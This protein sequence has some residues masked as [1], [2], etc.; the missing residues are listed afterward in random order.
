MARRRRK[1]EK[2]GRGRRG[3]TWR[4]VRQWPG[5]HFWATPFEVFTVDSSLVSTPVGHICTDM[6]SRIRFLQV[7]DWNCYKLGRLHNCILHCMHSNK[8]IGDICIGLNHHMPFRPSYSLSPS[9]VAVR[10]S[11]HN[12]NIHHLLH[13]IWTSDAPVLWCGPRLNIDTYCHILRPTFYLTASVVTEPSTTGISNADA[14][15]DDDDED[16]GHAR[17]LIFLLLNSFFGFS[18][19]SFCF[20]VGAL[21]K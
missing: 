4:C 15:D 10:I 21:H 20:C 8:D 9:A 3:T 16:A 11:F 17:H 12:S 13:G 7:I 2:K 1:R 6:N 14:A 5:W 18:T 19:D